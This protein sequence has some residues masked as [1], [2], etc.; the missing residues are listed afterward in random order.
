M[1]VFGRSIVRKGVVSADMLRVALTGGIATGKTHVLSRFAG[2]GVPTIDADQLVHDATRPG[3]A[4]VESIVQ[5]F[6]REIANSDGAIDRKR[7]GALVFADPQARRDL[8]RLLHPEVY[9][10]ID[11]WYAT[12][13]QDPHVRFG[14]ADIPLLYETGREHDFDKVIVT[15]CPPRQQIERLMTRD[16]LTRSEAEQRLAAQLPIE[17]KM[18]RADFVIRTDGTLEETNRQVEEVCRALRV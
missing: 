15:A 2:L 8:E 7:L 9:R 10:E 16:G 6:G 5:R 14:I 17:G 18:K 13:G 3:G 12:V 4:A 1:A 11:R